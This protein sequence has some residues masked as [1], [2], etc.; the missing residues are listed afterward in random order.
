[1]AVG[2]IWELWEQ[3]ARK[4]GES[5]SGKNY[6]E[7]IEF[8]CWA[9]SSNFCGPLNNVQTAMIQTGSKSIMEEK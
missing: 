8:Y 1:M 5:R 9:S 4:V 6:T 2:Y 3:K 7:F